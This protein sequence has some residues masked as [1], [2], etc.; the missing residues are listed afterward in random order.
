MVLSVLD[1][2]F[3][4]SA[5]TGLVQFFHV[6]GQNA[7][8]DVP[9]YA[10]SGYTSLILL[11][12]VFASMVRGCWDAT[13]F[14]FIAGLTGHSFVLVTIVIVASGGLG[15]LDTLWALEFPQEGRFHDKRYL[16]ED[17]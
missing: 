14:P 8:P 6:L 17:C 9:I 4:D 1:L 10:F 16:R 11:A 13:L 5:A 2:I 15:L 3:I 7:V 12:A